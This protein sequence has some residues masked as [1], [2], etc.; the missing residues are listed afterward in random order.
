MQPEV[1][2]LQSIIVTPV[3]IFRG[4]ERDLYAQHHIGKSVYASFAPCPVLRAPLCNPPLP[5][6]VREML[7][8][9]PCMRDVPE[10]AKFGKNSS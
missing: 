2:M 6:G 7:L 9:L 1:Q 5:R 8:M 4:Q 3:G 10:P